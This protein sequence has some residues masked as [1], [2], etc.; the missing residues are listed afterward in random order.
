MPSKEPATQPIAT[1]TIEPYPA[2]PTTRVVVVECEHAWTT[3]HL[4][5]APSR[6]NER[7]WV[8]SLLDAHEHAERCGCAART[9]QRLRCS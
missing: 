1:V 2:V 8:V 6:S 5:G 7:A 4:L 9:L 3:M